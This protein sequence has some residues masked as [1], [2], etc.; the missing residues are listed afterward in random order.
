MEHLQDF[1]LHLAIQVNQQIAA[2]D[3]VDLRERRIGQQAVLGEQH[4]L[5]DF[6]AD[7]VVVIVFDEIMPKAC[8]RY[9]GD[10]GLR[11]GAGAASGDRAFVDI[12]GEHLQVG[13]AALY[14]HLII[15]QDCQA[16]G[17]FAGR[18]AGRPDAQFFF[19]RRVGNRL[20][21][22]RQH[23]ALNGFEGFA[24]T[25]EVGHADQHV[26]EQGLGFFRGIL[27]VVVIGAEVRLAGDLHA[28]LDAAQHGGALVVFEI[29]TG[30]AAQVQQDFMQ[31]LFG[32]RRFVF[33]CRL[34]GFQ[35][36]I[37]GAG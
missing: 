13:L 9:V 23:I 31:A 3:Q 4:F 17:F 14:L 10:D 29:V 16:V 8:W 34:Q 27:Q 21:Q 18:A 7:P 19:F 37:I 24:V 26:A 6:L 1:P 28:P 12:G 25:E 20:H 30:A 11:I 2:N 22:L 35:V 5:A 36:G 33:V 15:E 32:D